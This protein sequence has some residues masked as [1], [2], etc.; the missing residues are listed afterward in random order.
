MLLTPFLWRVASDRTQ[1]RS[2]PYFPLMSSNYPSSQSTW[3]WL[4]HDVE[5]LWVHCWSQLSSVCISTLLLPDFFINIS[6]ILAAIFGQM[7]V[8]CTVWHLLCTST[9]QLSVSVRIIRDM[10]SV[11]SASKNNINYYKTICEIFGYALECIFNSGV[12]DYL[13]YKLWF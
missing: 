6:C 5:Y 13:L 1:L 11:G 3:L 8:L 2:V 9:M 4:C 12:G 10:L 7:A